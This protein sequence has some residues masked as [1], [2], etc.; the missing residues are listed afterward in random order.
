MTETEQNRLVLA[1]TVRVDE[2]IP[3]LAARLEPAEIAVIDAADLDRSSALSLLA[4]RPLAVLNVASSTTG[5]RPSFGAQLLVENGVAVVDDLG[6]DLMLLGEGEQV[7]IRGSEIYR[8]EQLI[9]AGKARLLGELQAEKGSG[10]N[11]LNASVEGLAQG[12]ALL[13]QRE[14]GTFLEGEGVP[15]IKVSKGVS[16]A[17]VIA[18]AYD[19]KRRS[20]KFKSMVADFS[21]IV[22]VADEAANQIAGI[23]RKPDVL[24]GDMSNVSE[25]I[26]RSGAQIVLL[27]RPDGSVA[28]LD[29][30]T[31][32]GL[33]Y[34]VMPTSASSVDAA[35]LLADKNGLQ[36]IITLGV[37]NGIEEFLGQNGSEVVGGFFVRLQAERKIVPLEVALRLYRPQISN[38][39]LFFLF[40]ACL[41]AMGVAV[42]FTPWGADAGFKIGDWIGGFWSS[43]EISSFYLG[44]Q[45]STWPT[46]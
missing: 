25:K 4:K 6:S 11:R 13:W 40:L 20:K 21:P 5:R 27:E 14:S 26:L 22:I 36:N 24:V 15:S 44:G 18:P 2:R 1:G 10:R 42:F 38:W 39:Q 7:E 3:R 9:A 43:P 12:A 29:R 17:L 16:S 30:V 45:N 35:I 8:G 28:G 37:P 33:N 23:K 31:N 41:L 46:V 19:F 34:S 32:Y